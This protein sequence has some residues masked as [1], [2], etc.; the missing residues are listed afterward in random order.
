MNEC[1]EINCEKQIKKSR[2]NIQKKKRM[3]DGEN[4]RKRRNKV[5]KI[6]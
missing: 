2:R 5:R 6:S 1:E 4:E 3:K